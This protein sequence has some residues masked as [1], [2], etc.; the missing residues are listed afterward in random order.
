MQDAYNLSWKLAAVLR[1]QAAACL[2][3]TYSAERAPVA[4]QIVLRANQSSREFGQF[5][6]AL[7]MTEA[8]T[9]TEMMQQI[10]ER[11]ANTPRGAAKRAALVKA[12]ELKNYEFNAHGVELGQFYESAAIVPDGSV[13]P[14]P[15]RDPELYYQPSTVPRPGSRTSGWETAR[16]SS[17]PST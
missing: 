5:F 6:D 9:E 2:L 14:E 13:R 12:M 15:D 11:K 4:R 8:T 16:A 17:P 1:G 10:E 3:D 7:G